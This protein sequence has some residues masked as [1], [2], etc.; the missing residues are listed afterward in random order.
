MTRSLLLLAVPLWLP[1][2]AGCGEKGHEAGRGGNPPAPVVTGVQVEVVKAVAVPDL[3][4]VVGTVRARTSAVVLARIPGTVTLLKVREGERVRKGQ[5]LARLDAQETGAAG[6]AAAAGSDEAQRALDEAEA[7]KRL[8]DVTFERYQRLYREQAIT[9]QEFDTKQ[10][11]REVAAQG[12]ARALARY[13]QAREGARAASRMADYARIVAPLS[14]VVT[15]KQVDQGSTV[16]PGQPLMTIDDQGS[17]LLELALPESLAARAKAGTPVQ[18]TL[19]ALKATFSARI[20]EIVPAADPQSRTF[21]A[22]VPLDRQ[23]VTTGMF[24]RA[25]IGLGSGANAILLPERAVVEHGAL[26]SVWVVEQGN[27]ARMRLVKTGK[28]VG[29]KVEIVSGLADGE[30]V[31][32]SGVEKVSEGAK[33]E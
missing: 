1:L 26:T 21:V 25:A 13:R 23:G 3:A 24:G 9:R 2:L 28:A 32:L 6:A 8:A 5:L 7:R 18:V 33:V 17:Y 30:R 19:D 27:I 4:E 11:E 22:K 14:G 10:T 16:F 31:V 15:A 29:G 12:V 20:A